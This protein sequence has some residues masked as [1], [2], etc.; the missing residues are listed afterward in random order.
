MKIEKNKVVSFHYKLS[1]EGTQL[2]SSH[3]EEPM[4]FLFGHGGLIS[5][6]E[7]AMSG[8]QTGDTFNVTLPPEKAYGHRSNDAVQR[9]PIKQLGTK[10]KLKPGDAVAVNTSKGPLDVA[11]IKAGKFMADVDAN[12][13]LAGRTLTFD[14]DIVDVRDATDE[15]LS[16]GH[17]HDAGGHRH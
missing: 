7:D 4:L 6:L 10:R 11:I 2:E 15:E 3:G 16:H 13:P 8:R 17:A 9:V 12:H 14:V 1:D 5:G